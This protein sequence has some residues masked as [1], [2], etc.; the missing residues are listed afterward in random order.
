[1]IHSLSSFQN[2]FLISSLIKTVFLVKDECW[3]LSNEFLTSMEMLICFSPLTYWCIIV[4]DLLI[5]NHSYNSR[6]TLINRCILF[7]QYRARSIEVSL[8]WESPL[9]QMIGNFP[10]YLYFLII[11]LNFTIYLLKHIFLT[12]WVNWYL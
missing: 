6:N 4:I 2:F 12:S 11:T 9:H 5:I 1:M 3:I 10:F 7:L 8:F